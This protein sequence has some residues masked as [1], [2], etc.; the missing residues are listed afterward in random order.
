MQ[1][2][3]TL[4]N[5]IQQ[6]EIQ[7]EKIKSDQLTAEVEYHEVNLKLKQ[8]TE[9]QNQE[10]DAL[11]ARVNTKAEALEILNSEIKQ[12]ENAYNWEQ[13]CFAEKHKELDTAIER[14][15]NDKKSLMQQLSESTQNLKKVEHDCEN[16]SHDIVKL[17]NKKSQLI[18]PEKETA[19]VQACFRKQRSVADSSENS[20]E[21]ISISNFFSQRS[22]K[23]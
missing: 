21:G 17:E 18:A 14:L 16:L 5:K 2:K 22:N 20:F 10:L 3:E 11:K 8:Q 15:N 4:E 12:I 7:M 1:Q 6:A 23:K 19:V 13:A 9:I